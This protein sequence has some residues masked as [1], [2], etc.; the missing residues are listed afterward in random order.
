[1]VWLVFDCWDWESCSGAKPSRRSPGGSFCCCEAASRKLGMAHVS[2]LNLVSFPSALHKGR[3]KGSAQGPSFVEYFQ[4]LNFVSLCVLFLDE[5]KGGGRS[6][7]L[8]VQ[9]WRYGDGWRPVLPF[10]ILGG[11]G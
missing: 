6:S 2:S 10:C 3:H 7:S 11:L 8:S 4:W 1:M 5:V 9:K